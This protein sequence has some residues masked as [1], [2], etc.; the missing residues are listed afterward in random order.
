M[1]ELKQLR[2]HWKACRKTHY[3]HFL[4]TNK[5]DKRSEANCYMLDA[6]VIELDQVIKKH[7][8]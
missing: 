6:V 5:L 1:A 8:K 4:L 7:D 2:E 3:E